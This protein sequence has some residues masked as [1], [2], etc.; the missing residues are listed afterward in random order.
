MEERTREMP[1]TREYVDEDG[2]LVEPLVE[3]KVPPGAPTLGGP[4]PP[5]EGSLA[6]R[7]ATRSE[8][9]EKQ[10]SERFPIPGWEDILEVELRALGY[11]ALRQALTRNERVRD[12]A[13]RELYTVADQLLMAT[14]GFWEVPQNGGQPRQMDETWESLAKRLPNCPDGAT[15]RQALLFLVGDKRLH[16][17][18]QDWGEWAK[19]VDKQVHDEVQADFGLT[20]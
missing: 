1:A 15:P 12:E 11:R 10:T 3:D 16:F 18:A 2:D 5:Q 7:M 20:G 19:T 8:E 14:V 9:L 4:A 17:L 13:T 6:A